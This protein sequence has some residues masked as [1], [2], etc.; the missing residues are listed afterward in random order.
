MPTPEI[1]ERVRQLDAELAETQ[2][3]P[4]TAPGIETLRMQVKTVMLEPEHLPH[5]KS[6][7]D[8]LLFHYVGFQIDHPQ[9]AAA[10]ERVTSSALACRSGSDDAMLCSPD[11]VEAQSSSCSDDDH[12]VRDAEPRPGIA[13]E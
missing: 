11:D 4:A 10:M 9:L 13:S 1:I 2:P 8:K 7:G 5:Y 6:L 12:G 3:N